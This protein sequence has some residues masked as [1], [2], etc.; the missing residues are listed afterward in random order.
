MCAA[1]IALI[2]NH[3]LTAMADAVKGNPVAFVAMNGFNAVTETFD[4]VDYFSYRAVTAPTYKSKKGFDPDF[5]TYTQAMTSPD[6]DE[7]KA[8]MDLLAEL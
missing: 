7:W 6:S 1:M 4:E 5:P 2:G 8:A 3:H